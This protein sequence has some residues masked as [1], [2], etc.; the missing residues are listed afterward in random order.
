MSNNPT[1]RIIPHPEKSMRVYRTKTDKIVEGVVV[2]KRGTIMYRY[3]VVGRP[4]EIRAFRLARGEYYREIDKGNYTGY[5]LWSDQRRFNKPMDLVIVADGSNVVVAED[6]LKLSIIDK[7]KQAKDFGPVMEMA[8]AQRLAD[9]YVSDI[10][11]PVGPSL[12]APKMTPSGNTDV[13][14]TDDDIDMDNIPEG[15]DDENESIEDPLNL[16]A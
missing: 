16:G 5:P 6:D 4:D 1:L 12:D 15:D 11:N 10:A 14:V 7:M 9:L 8:I 13:N 3:L 2:R